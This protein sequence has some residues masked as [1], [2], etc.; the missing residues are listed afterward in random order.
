MLQILA[1]LPNAPENI[2][3]L[4]KLA[5]AT[6]E[7]LLQLATDWET[8][9]Q[10]LIDEYRQLRESSQAAHRGWRGKL[11]EIKQLRQDIKQL[12]ATI[13]QREEKEATLR[14]QLEAAPKD[15]KREK[16]LRKIVE[17]L[18]STK[19]QKIEILKVRPSPSSSRLSSLTLFL[20][21]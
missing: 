16:Y 17:V 15:L 21:L 10:P 2:T 1:L 18:K 6:G 5:A 9:R 3:E 14:A 12:L 4:E 7:R 13:R 20:S 11:E 8:R 19:K